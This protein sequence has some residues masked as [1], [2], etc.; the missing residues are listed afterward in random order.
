MKNRN[1]DIDKIMAENRKPKWSDKVFEWSIILLS[2]IFM[3]IM[4]LNIETKKYEI[5]NRT[6]SH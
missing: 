6:K 5:N 3:P 2:I 4:F 1:T